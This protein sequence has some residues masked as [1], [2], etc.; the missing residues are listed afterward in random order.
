MTRCAAE[1]RHRRR[2]PAFFPAPPH[3]QAL[4][5][6]KDQLFH[7]NYAAT[8]LGAGQVERAREQFVEFEALYGVRCVDVADPGRGAAARTR[9][10]LSPPLRAM[11]RASPRL[12]ALDEEARASDSE[13]VEQRVLLAQALELPL[14]DDPATATSGGRGATTDSGA[15]RG[16]RR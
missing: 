14:S 5:L 12:Q 2:C 8:L 7:L 3:A 6:E 10:L 16:G 11:N 1:R 4:S 13:I 9:P 15:T